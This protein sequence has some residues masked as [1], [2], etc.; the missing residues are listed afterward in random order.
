M[1]KETKAGG[2]LSSKAAG[3]TQ[4]VQGQ[5]VLQSESLSQKE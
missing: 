4:W 5:P 3:A 2:S 1:Q